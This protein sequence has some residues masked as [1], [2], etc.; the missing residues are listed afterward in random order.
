M[1]AG[2]PKFNAA[3]NAGSVRVMLAAAGLHVSQINRKQADEKENRPVSR[4]ILSS[5][6][7]DGVELAAAERALLG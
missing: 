2:R 1:T 3:A 7:E 5:T 4:K 6:Y